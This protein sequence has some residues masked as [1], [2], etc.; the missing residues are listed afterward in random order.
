MIVSVLPC[1]GGLDST[2]E[3]LKPWTPSC[4]PTGTLRLDSTYEG[5]KLVEARVAAPAEGRLDSTYEGLKLAYSTYSCK[6]SSVF[7]QYL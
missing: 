6:S 1:R 2:Y 7:G 4:G 3:G 5:L